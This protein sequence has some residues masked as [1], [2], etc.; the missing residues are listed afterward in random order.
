ME[1]K[2][3]IKKWKKL[4]TF[5]NWKDWPHFDKLFESILILVPE[6]LSFF[7]WSMDYVWK[8]IFLGFRLFTNV[9][10]VFVGSCIDYLWVF[11]FWGFDL[12]PFKWT[13]KKNFYKR[14]ISHYEDDDILSQTTLLCHSFTYYTIEE[15]AKRTKKF[16]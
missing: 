14:I 16:K 3:K 2:M 1:I 11:D 8:I 9:V 13:L 4:F 15:R 6:F 10:L 5:F 12:I 7:V